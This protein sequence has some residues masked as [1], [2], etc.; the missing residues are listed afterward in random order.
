LIPDPLW[1]LVTC[2]YGQA[3]QRMRAARDGDPQSG[4]MSLEWIVIASILV[5]AAVGAGF[6]FKNKITQ[7]EGSVP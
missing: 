7:W 3:R 5:V 1:L 4:A 2:L 6:F